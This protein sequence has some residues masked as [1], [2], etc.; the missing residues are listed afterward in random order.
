MNNIYTIGHILEVYKT[1]RETHR[2]S[3]EVVLSVA[4]AISALARS[5]EDYDKEY[6]EKLMR[7]EE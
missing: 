4:A 3:S 7:S 2:A 1:Y 5:D 6:I